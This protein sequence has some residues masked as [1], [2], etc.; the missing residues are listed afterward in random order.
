MA[1][2]PKKHLKRVT[3]PHSWLMNKMGGNFAVRPAQGPHKLRESIPLQVVLRDKLNLALNGREA[4]LILHQKEGMIKVDKKIR[5]NHK[6]P[7]GFMD[8]IEI[9]KM[10]TNYR[11]LYDS[12]ARFTF[13]RI[14]D[15][16]A[17]FKLCKVEK[18][19]LGPNK[20]TYLVT[21][22]GRTIRFADKEIKIGD[23]VKFN[24]E[25]NEVEDFISMSVGNLA[26]CSNGNNRGRVGVID[27]INKF[28]NNFDLITIKDGNGH[29]F[30][31]RTS[32]IT[33]IGKGSKSMITLPKG[34]GI[35]LSIIEEAQKRESE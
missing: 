21:H 23:T 10:K 27:H 25:K 35:S 34:E 1:R 13:V 24:L 22:D 33:A 17:K 15:N 30:T 31:T 4:Q 19:A 7:V 8:V 11:V 20:I 18:K 26:F 6:Y 16:E 14:N 32:Y 2:G 3:A 28:D 29:S 9:P 12:K 5:R